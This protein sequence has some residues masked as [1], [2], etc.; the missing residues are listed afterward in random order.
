MNENNDLCI[1][2]LQG[3]VINQKYIVKE[4][5][6]TGGMSIL[7]R[8]KRISD[9]KDGVMKLCDSNNI[10]A[11]ESIV[12]EVSVLQR[13]KCKPVAKLIDIVSID[14][15]PAF[16]MEYLEG[17]TLDQYLKKNM[18]INTDQLV[19]IVSNVCDVVSSLHQISPPVF[20]CDMKPSNVMVLNDGSARLID[21][22]ATLQYDADRVQRGTWRK[23]GTIGYA[24]P[25]QLNT[26]TE[27][28]ARTD[29]YGIGMLVKYMYGFLGT[30][31]RNIERIIT[32]CTCFSK[33]LRYRECTH[34]LCD[35]L[36]LNKSC[37]IIKK[38]FVP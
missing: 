24:A 4:L 16:V 34:L 29:I 36:S 12:N 3:L 37:R 13:L 30:H 11:C 33:E 5:I 15:I 27:I 2:E 1:E 19:N 35:I 8:V 31:N 32:K 18:I 14:R 25:E 10:V 22:G 26:Y 9:N 7:Y 23:M 38:V 17:D 6:S 21:F 20:Y 28:D